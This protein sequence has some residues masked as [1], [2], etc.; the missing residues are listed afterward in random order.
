VRT[1][2]RHHEAQDQTP[3]SRAALNSSDSTAFLENAAMYFALP[4]RS[5]LIALACLATFSLSSTAYADS[6]TIRLSVLKEGWLIGASGGNG[7]LNFM[8]SATR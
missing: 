4:S 3:A 8:V 2:L 1:F 7:V 6:G 5:K